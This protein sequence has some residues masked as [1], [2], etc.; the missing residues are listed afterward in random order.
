MDPVP[1]QNDSEEEEEDHSLI[2]TEESKS[3]LPIP[4]DVLGTPG[5]VGRKSISKLEES[6]W[7]DS[8]VVFGVGEEEEDSTD[9][10]GKGKGKGKATS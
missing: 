1:Y 7:D 6:V 2:Q 10:G 9:G 5:N 8:E 3:L 4:A